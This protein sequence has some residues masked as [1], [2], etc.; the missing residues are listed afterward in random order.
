MWE[1]GF[2]SPTGYQAYII[3]MSAM[4][5]VTSS[6]FQ[7]AQN[8]KQDTAKILG[9]NLILTKI[10]GSRAN[11]S[12]QSDSDILLLTKHKVPHTSRENRQISDLAARY[13]LESGVLISPVVYAIQDFEKY[14]NYSPVLYWIQEEGVDI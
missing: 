13:L 10:Y 5:K 2:D 4:K 12:A 3:K 7:L 6:D 9:D 8:F 11:G 1:Q 14:K